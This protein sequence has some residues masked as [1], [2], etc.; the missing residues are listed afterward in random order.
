MEALSQAQD[1]LVAGEQ[2]GIPGPTSRYHSQGGG[3]MGAPRVSSCCC[4][5][6]A[7]RS[8]SSPLQQCSSLLNRRPGHIPSVGT[9]TLRQT[10]RCTRSCRKAAVWAASCP[11][12]WNSESFCRT[13]ASDTTSLSA[14]RMSRACA[15]KTPTSRSCRRGSTMSRRQTSRPS[16]SAE[17]TSRSDS[18]SAEFRRCSTCRQMPSWSCSSPTR[19]S[20]TSARS[21][22][23]NS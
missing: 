8:P 23:M 20:P 15:G 4:S 9:L 18:E 22:R 12:D 21:V 14:D 19:S 16:A 17:G 11:P 6:R 1:L 2:Q 10:L 7:A 3:A 13:A 5:R